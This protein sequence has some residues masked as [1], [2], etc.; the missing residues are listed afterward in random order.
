MGEGTGPR[1]DLTKRKLAHRKLDS[2]IQAN[3]VSANGWGFI[4]VH[5]SLNDRLKNRSVNKGVVLQ[6]SNFHEVFN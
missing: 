6:Q 3:P 4:P 1:S 5:H 2:E